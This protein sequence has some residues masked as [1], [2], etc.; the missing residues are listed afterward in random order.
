MTTERTVGSDGLW[1]VLSTEVVYDCPPY[2]T[3]EK[4]E[5]LLPDGRRIED[6]HQL[7]MPSACIVCALTE[8]NELVLLRG[9]KHGIG[10]IALY[11]P[12]GVIE[13]GEDPLI[14]AKRELI[15]ETGYSAK[16]WHSLGEFVPHGNYG[17]GRAYV[18]IAKQAHRMQ[19]PNSDDL[20]STEIE[21]V[22]M[23]SAQESI[24]DGEIS[25][26][27]SVAAIGLAIQYLQVSS[28]MD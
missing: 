16:A 28:S 19:N 22:D 10:K 24:R 1:E 18:F 8:G 23:E 6:Y 15:E 25:S 14:A 13:I 2:L 21:V 12:G 27:A 5:V 26:L 20:E 17:C 4:Q 11:L 3:V 9:Y 7:L